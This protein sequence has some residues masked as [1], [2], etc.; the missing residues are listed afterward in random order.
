M[1]TSANIAKATRYIG[2]QDKG[3][4]QSTP[5]SKLAME[6]VE[7]G[8]ATLA[9]EIEA[10]DDGARAPRLEDSGATI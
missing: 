3:L 4:E 5:G 7:E 6:D 2:R 8:I 9:T 1:S 10:L